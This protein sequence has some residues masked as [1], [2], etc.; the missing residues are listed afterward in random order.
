M[1][2][3]EDGD[4]N[5]KVGKKQ[6]GERKGRAGRAAVHRVT[7]PQGWGK[8]GAPY[9]PPHSPS[10][11]LGCL[12]AMRHRSYFPTM[13]QA[14]TRPSAPPETR[15][16]WLKNRHFTAPSC[17][18]RVCKKRCHCFQ[19]LSVQTVNPP[20][21]RAGDIYIYIYPTVPCGPVAPV[22]ARSC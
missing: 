18:M 12:K 13:L 6:R 4:R 5:G 15:C 16:H 20:L 19:T 1:S 10:T 14:M 7:R 9:S 3:R 21:A 17:P 8:E 11:Y 22:Q 2:R